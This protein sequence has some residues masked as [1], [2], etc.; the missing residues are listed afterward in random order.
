MFSSLPQHSV[1]LLGIGH[2]NAHVLRMWRMRPLRDARLTCV[3]NFAEATYSGMLPG[4][5]AGLYPPE[6]MQIDLVRMC[7]AAGARLILSEVTSVEAENRLLRFNDRPPLPFDVLSI[8]IG[9]VPRRDGV[10]ADEDTVLPIKPMQTFLPR[11]DERLPALCE[12]VGGRPLRI[13]VVGGGAGGVEI[14]FCLPFHLRKAHGGLP[15]ELLLVDGGPQL[16][17]GLPTKTGEVAR[18]ALETRGVRVL[19]GQGVR[20]AAAG[21]LVFDDGREEPVDLVLWST[22]AAAP[23]ELTQWGLPVDG[24]GF[25]IRRRTLK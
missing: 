12:R 23:P 1:V 3:S 14:A 13:A 10:R 25:L 17:A 5:L 22:G 7:A 9:S 19:L 6:R 8:G 11:L 16:A 21:R 2:T 4:T 18:Q 24:Q 20:E 15:H